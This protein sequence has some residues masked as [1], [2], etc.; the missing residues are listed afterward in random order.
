MNPTQIEHVLSL[1]DVNIDDS[2]KRLH[3]EIVAYMTDHINAL[4]SQIAEKGSAEIP[5]SLGSLT[6][7]K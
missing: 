4:A 3:P 6:I 2:M 5:T 1:I 7:S